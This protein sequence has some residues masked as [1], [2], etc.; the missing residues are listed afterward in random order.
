M[1]VE[2]SAVVSTVAGSGS[3]SY[4]DGSGLNARFKLPQRVT[5]DSNGNIIVADTNN[6][7]LRKVTPDG[8]TPYARLFSLASDGR[9]RQ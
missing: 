9:N 7:R 1:G 2:C 8:G 5:I 6:Q 3:S 4:A